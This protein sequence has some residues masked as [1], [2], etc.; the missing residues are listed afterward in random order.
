MADTVLTAVK[1]RTVFDSRG[2][3]TLE[4]DFHT[5]AGFARIAAP[6]GAPGSRGEFE[7]PAYAPG[8]LGE[9]IAILDKEI[10]PAILGFDLA[11]QEKFDTLLTE[12][13]G[14]ANF[15]RI[16]GNTSTVLS[17]AA[18]N[19]AANALGVPLYKHMHL[20]GSWTLPLP[21]G[22][23]VGGGAH[24]LGP[25]PDMQ[26][27]LVIPVGARD[28]RH[29]VE[30]NLAVHQEAGRILEARGG[31]FA[32]GMDDEDAWAAD[33]NDFE[34]LEVVEQAKKI[35]EDK[36][37]V[38]LRLGIDLAA[39][40]LWNGAK[41][42]YVYEREGV[43]R[44]RQEQ[45]DY[46]LGLIERFDMVYCEDA[47]DSND[48]DGFAL[49]NS[50]ASKR[51]YV[52]ADDVYASNSGRTSIGIGKGCSRAMIVKPNQVGTLTG[53]KNTAVLARQNGVRP[54]I[55]NRSGETPDVSISHLG[56]AWHAVGIKCGVRGGVRII[57]LNELIRIEQDVP[58]I[59]LSKWNW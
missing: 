47:F 30:L 36:E 4:V 57:K 38:E 24:S 50:Q 40:R 20:G 9:T 46:I 10:V 43:A 8:G 26:E 52:S 41:Q 51:C 1:H 48:Y 39:D 35:V 22:N 56:V 54:I 14:T 29:A 3:E 23:I 37:G 5:R 44:E 31:G 58:G 17:L 34:A 45:L 25:A 2:V 33:L 53:A 21:L 15:L 27:H 6:F 16:G 32:G 18:A 55:S 13:D 11:E 59:A 12:I 42:R 49:L 19:A 28:M 7:A